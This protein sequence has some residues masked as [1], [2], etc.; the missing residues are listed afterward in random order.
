MLMVA[1]GGNKNESIKF[2]CKIYEPKN[3]SKLFKII[4]NKEEVNTE[5]VNEILN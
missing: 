5:M 4:E 3:L 2:I 1:N